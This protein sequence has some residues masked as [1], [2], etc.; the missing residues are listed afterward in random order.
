MTPAQLVPV[1]YVVI[2][3]VRPY[4]GAPS[5]SP[6]RPPFR[7][8]SYPRNPDESPRLETL[9]GHPTTL[10]PPP[11]HARLW[12][13]PPRL[14]RTSESP[15]RTASLS[16]TNPS[17]SPYTLIPYLST[18]Q[19]PLR[20]PLFFCPVSSIPTPLSPRSKSSVRYFP[21]VLFRRILFLTHPD[22][23]GRVLS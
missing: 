10:R 1:L 19:Y 16:A 18:L 13:S 9:Y 22:R 5:A 23:S 7:R 14:R 4:P 6:P 3:R 17:P 20:L 2:P 15:S 8:L 21:Q 11:R 12:S